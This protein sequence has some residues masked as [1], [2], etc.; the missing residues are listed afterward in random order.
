[1]ALVIRDH[2]VWRNEAPLSPIRFITMKKAGGRGSHTHTVSAFTGTL[3]YVHLH[4]QTLKLNCLYACLHT[5]MHVRTRTHTNG[6]MSWILLR[7]GC[8]SVKLDKFTDAAC[9]VDSFYLKKDLL[10]PYSVPTRSRSKPLHHQRV[11]KLA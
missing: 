3:F 10:W 6:D 2:D 9:G 11:A 7:V 4:P 8:F 5:L 1:M